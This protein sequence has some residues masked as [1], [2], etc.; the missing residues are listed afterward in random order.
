MHLWWINIRAQMTP[1]SF[2]KMG[3]SFFVW[4]LELPVFKNSCSHMIM[5]LFLSYSCNLVGWPDLKLYFSSQVHWR[6]ASAL[7]VLHVQ[8]SPD[9]RN[10]NLIVWSHGSIYYKIVI[11]WLSNHIPADNHWYTWYISQSSRKRY[12][13]IFFLLLD[14]LISTILWLHPFFKQ[15]K[16]HFSH[17]KDLAFLEKMESNNHGCLL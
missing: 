16:L 17:K 14:N 10:Y 1:Y 5:E 9:T 3:A 7:E 8:G 15:W 2:Q 13:A 6:L 12:W 11:I 4:N